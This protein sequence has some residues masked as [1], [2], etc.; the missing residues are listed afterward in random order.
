MVQLGKGP[1]LAAQPLA[2]IG[3][4]AV[5][6]QDLERD[7]APQP[8]VARA[9]DLAH[10]AGAERFE[11]AIALEGA[12]RRER[13]V[14]FGWIQVSPGVCLLGCAPRAREGK[15]FTRGAGSGSMDLR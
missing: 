4:A 2:G 3:V 11:N 15:D 10:A 12:A 5:G 8:L 14:R 6:A 13:V 9:K 1:R 7:V